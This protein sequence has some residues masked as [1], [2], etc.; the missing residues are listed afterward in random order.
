[1]KTRLPLFVTLV[2]IAA[3]LGVSLWAWSAIPAGAR[4]PIHWGIDG[5]P[6]GFAG[7]TVGLFFAPCLAALI[8]A[9]FAVIPLIEPRRANLL[10]SSKFYRASWI[11]VVALM[12]AVHGATVAAAL[13]YPVDAGT[14]VLAAA[15]LL[16]IVIGNFL[17][18]TRSNFFAGVRTPWT[19]SSEYSW[20][21]THSLTG[22]LFIASVL[23]AL[24]AVIVL[25]PKIGT[26]V[27][28]ATMAVTV[29]ASLVM[30]YV[31]WRRD[32]DRRTGELAS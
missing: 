5:K 25:G 30:S 19:L 20:Q 12:A 13:R 14:V 29:S 2:L 6:N 7:K 23:C 21:R 10:S 18:K 17:G 16:F 9:V 28:M 15:S 3:M 11:G 31:Y 8:G 1:M 26:F 32:P 22:K 27:L 4:L 24:G